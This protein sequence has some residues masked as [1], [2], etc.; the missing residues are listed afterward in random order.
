LNTATGFG[1]AAQGRKEAGLW[2]MLASVV[3]RAERQLERNVVFP[4]GRGK[5]EVKYNPQ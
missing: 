5:I 3:R 1:N 2:V 4:E